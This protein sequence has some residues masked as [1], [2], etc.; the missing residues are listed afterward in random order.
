[1]RLNR[2]CVC[3]ALQ[4]L[5]KVEANADELVDKAIHYL[6][7]SY[8]DSKKRWINIPSAA[9]KYPRAPWWNY[10]NVLKWAGWGNPSAEILGY[11]L[12]HAD[13]IN[14]SFLAKVSEQAVQHLNGIA[15]PEQHEVKCYIRL[16]QRADENLRAKLYDR[17]SAQVK[18][19]AKIDPK[20]W[21][22]YTATPLTFIDSPDSP[23]A[24]LFDKQVLLDNAEY[25]RKQ[26][27][28]GHWEPTWQ[29]GRFEK[30]WAQAKKDWSGK[31]TVE[32]LELLKAFNVQIDVQREEPR[33]K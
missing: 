18:E 7:N 31:L 33:T 20:D 9:D 6:V 2:I 22:G 3:L 25:I 26:I 8:D 14:A 16:Y 11:L 27:V 24:N 10:E 32:N 13:K 1:M 29:W 12:Q 30:E 23:F 4:Y 15:E 28:E 5:A 17:L 19:L 21:E